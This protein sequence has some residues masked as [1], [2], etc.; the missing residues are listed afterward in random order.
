MKKKALTFLEI[1][2]AATVMVVAMI[3][4]FGMLSKQTVETDKNASQ[5]FAINKATEVLNTLLDN[6]SFVAIREGNP[7]YLRVDDLPKLEKYSDLD[8]DWVK[9]MSSIL[10]NHTN[11][12]SNG[13]KCR[14]TVTDSKGITYLIHLRV[15]D[16]VSTIKHNKPEQIKIGESFPN[17]YPYDFSEQQEVNFAFLK[18]PSIITSSKWTQDFAE[19]PNET[20]KPFTELDL[21]SK[22]VSESKYNIYLDEGIDNPKHSYKNPTAE[23]FTAKMVMSK[24]PYNVEESM[25]WC[26]FKRLIVQVQWNMEPKYYSD[27]ENP[28]GNT[29]RIHLIA[30]KGDIDS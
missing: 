22:G 20:G 17:S 9:K 1:L 15:E 29:Q 18:N 27:P 4:I 28:K 19:S 24:V 13:Y 25:A 10:F 5:A 12:E 11:Q 3:P 23:R 26:P 21:N 2:I 6:V 16:V 8:S 7:G 30:I 14:G